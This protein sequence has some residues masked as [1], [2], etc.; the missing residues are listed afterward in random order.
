M[1][2]PHI[3][4]D[5]LSH[6]PAPSIEPLSGTEQVLDESGRMNEFVVGT[7]RFLTCDNKPLKLI[8][9]GPQNPRI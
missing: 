3:G 2:L 6:S 8:K 5:K 7:K 1:H 4:R 9:T